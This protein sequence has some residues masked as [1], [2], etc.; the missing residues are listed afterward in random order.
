MVNI[1][2]SEEPFQAQRS[3]TRR[4]SRGLIAVRITARSRAMNNSAACRLWELVPGRPTPRLH[5]WQWVFPASSYYLDRR[6]GIR[7]RYHAHESVIQKAVQEATGRAGLT[8][9]ATPHSFR[10]S[11]ATEQLEEGYDIR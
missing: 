8:K 1:S 5:G 10:H 3:L 11:F 2:A 7:R 6:T 4:Q 9:P